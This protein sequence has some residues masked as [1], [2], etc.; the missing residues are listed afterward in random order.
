MFHTIFDDFY[1][2]TKRNDE[3]LQTYHTE[4]STVCIMDL[5]GYNKKNLTV[6]LKEGV[7]TISGKRSI[8]IKGLS[9]PVKNHSISKTY[10]IG[11]KYDEEKIKAEVS[12]GILTITLP[13]KEEKKKRVI[14][15]LN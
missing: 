7:L 1:T 10:T 14:S 11:N 15:L 9:T 6:E 12:D 5:P 3:L 4:E 13:Y 8:E 2:L